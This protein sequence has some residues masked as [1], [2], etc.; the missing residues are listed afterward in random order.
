MNRHEAGLAKFEELFALKVPDNGDNG[1]WG[2]VAIDLLFG[3]IWT[4]PGLTLRDRSMITVATLIVQGRCEELELH[5]R[6]ALN[7]GISENEINEMITHLSF[8][9]GFPAGR[10][11]LSSAS[12]VFRSRKSQSENN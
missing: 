3:E 9:A 6:G 5:L 2:Q 8:Y 1:L 12:K 11:A 7:V 4:R 10:N